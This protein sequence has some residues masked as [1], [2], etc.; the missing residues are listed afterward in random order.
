VACSTPRPPASLPV[1]RPR[2]PRPLAETC[3][4]G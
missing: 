1:T 4:G 3:T 2:A